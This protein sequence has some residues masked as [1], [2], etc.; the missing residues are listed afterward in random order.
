MGFYAPAQLVRD[1]KEHGVE[2]RAVDVNHS[3]W[4]CSMEGGAIRLGLRMIVGMRQAD[5]VIIEQVQPFRSMEEF[6]T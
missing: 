4:D 2:V 5:G 3:L 6:Q 1:A